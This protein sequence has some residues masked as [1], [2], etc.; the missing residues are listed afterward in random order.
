MPIENG[1]TLK[2]QIAGATFARL[3]AHF[4]AKKIITLEATYDELD[5]IVTAGLDAVQ[6]SK[7][8]K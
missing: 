7:A 6:K 5:R 1:T 2:G 4:K 8:S 3:K